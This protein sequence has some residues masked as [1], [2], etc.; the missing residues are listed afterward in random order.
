M[1]TILLI[2]LLLASSVAGAQ[3]TIMLNFPDKSVQV[4]SS[5]GFAFAYLA[6]D[7]DVTACKSD[8]IFASN[9]GG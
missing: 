7:I 6:L 2:S 5:P 9:M 1:R 4:C 3:Y 8:T